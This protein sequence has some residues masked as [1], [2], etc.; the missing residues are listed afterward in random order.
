MTSGPSST[1]QKFEGIG[2]FTP[3]GQDN[4]K[5]VYT[6][7]VKY[8]TRT[9][10]VKVK[11]D[12]TGLKPEEI[13]AKLATTF[14]RTKLAAKSIGLG[15]PGGVK[16]FTMTKEG[17]SAKNMNGKEM[18][19]N[20]LQEKLSEAKNIKLAQKKE[21]DSGSTIIT[22]KKAE[23]SYDTD[24]AKEAKL[25]KIETKIKD[26]EYL[27]S[28]IDTKSQKKETEP[29]IE[30]SP[31][32]KPLP[33]PPKKP[34]K[35]QSKEEISKA[36][37][38]NAPP[39]PQLD[40]KFK[41]ANFKKA[42]NEAPNGQVEGD[43]LISEMKKLCKE[44]AGPQGKPDDVKKEALNKLIDSLPDD[45]RKNF[46]RLLYD[47]QFKTETETPNTTQKSEHKP[48]DSE[49]KEGPSARARFGDAPTPPKTSST[50]ETV[51]KMADAALKADSDKKHALKAKF[52]GKMGS[53]RVK[54][55]S[56]KI[57]KPPTK[58]QGQAPTPPQWIKNS[59]V[60]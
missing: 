60:N 50:P 29:E 53:N 46:I 32:P 5:S 16:S 19:L 55:S 24:Q 2:N 17:I 20:T 41:L 40:F 42:F 15:E 25:Q 59:K 7:Q 57:A 11:L 30:I 36:E 18:D 33:T 37:Q 44:I 27:M 23:K 13:Q 9:Y 51:S 52:E 54:A 21:L 45:F 56:N 58:P 8:G 49:V 34:E 22:G 47:N 28:I 26:L 43:K 31:K 38:P 35:P 14:E 4:N 39:K 12:T 48:T 3:S 6:Q 10:D 1:G